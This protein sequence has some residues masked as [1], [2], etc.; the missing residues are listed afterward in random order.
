MSEIPSEN[1]ASFLETMAK[2]ILNWSQGTTFIA[3]QQKH[4]GRV[5][6]SR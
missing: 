5:C 3:E 6:G 4:I 2:G 1:N